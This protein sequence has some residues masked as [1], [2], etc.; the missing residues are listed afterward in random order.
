[1]VS[2][3]WKLQKLQPIGVDFW[4]TFS[5]QQT[6]IKS[7]TLLIIIRNMSTSSQKKKN[8]RGS[9][10]IHRPG[11]HIY[12]RIHVVI[13]LAQWPGGNIDL[14]SVARP[15]VRTTKRS[16][17][18]TSIPLKG[19]W[20]SIQDTSSNTYCFSEH[21]FLEQ[22]RGQQF[23][24]DHPCGWMIVIIYSFRERNSPTRRWDSGGFFKQCSSTISVEGRSLILI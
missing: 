17:K 13:L 15:W 16:S 7:L 3:Q 24:K 9:N 11:H 10:R 23:Q 18:K 1:M 19:N 5:V 14:V 12:H 21:I 8:T 6:A 2:C 20:S 22:F 4:D